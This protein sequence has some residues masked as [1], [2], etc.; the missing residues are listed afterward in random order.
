MEKI[1]QDEMYT[2]ESIFNQEN[3]V[4]LMRAEFDGED[5][6]VV[7]RFREEEHGVEAT[8]IAVLITQNIFDRLVPPPDPYEGMEMED[9]RAN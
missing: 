3:N 9:S 2:F 7:I 5:V 8:P 1:T 6:A 4:A